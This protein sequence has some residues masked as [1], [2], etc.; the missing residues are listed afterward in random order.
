MPREITAFTATSRCHLDQQVPKDL[1]VDQV[2]PEFQGP[3]ETM[4]HREEWDSQARLVLLV[5]QGQWV[6]QDPKVTQVISK[7][8]L[9]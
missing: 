6:F 9:D 3:R 8:Y 7:L 4:D 2:I 5:S 1:P